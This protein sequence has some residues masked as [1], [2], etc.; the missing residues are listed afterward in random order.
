MKI[1]IILQ[2]VSY[3]MTIFISTVF[4]R[5]TCRIFMLILAEILLQVMHHMICRPVGLCIGGRDPSPHIH[6]LTREWGDS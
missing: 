5:K 4:A 3:R 6:R 2:L 1:F